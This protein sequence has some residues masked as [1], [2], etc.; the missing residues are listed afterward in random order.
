MDGAPGWA[1]W[2][3]NRWIVAIASL[4]VG[5][6]VGGD[7]VAQTAGS[8]KATSPDLLDGTLSAGGDLEEDEAPRTGFFRRPTALDPYFAWKRAIRERYGLGFGG[9]WGVLWQ[10]YSNSLIGDGQTTG[11]IFYR[12]HVTPNFAITPDL[13]VIVKP[14]LNPNLNT[15]WVAGVRARISF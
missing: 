14:S 7:T 6:A 12:F 13:Q 3:R 15:L 9:S 1:R 10:N 8:D 2:R 11:E 5:L 4:V